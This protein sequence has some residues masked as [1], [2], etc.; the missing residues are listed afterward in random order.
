MVNKLSVISK[1]VEQYLIFVDTCSLMHQN[2]S[3]F[4]N[5]RFNEKIKDYN[6][7]HPDNKTGYYIIQHVIDELKKFTDE[8]KWKTKI[9][10]REKGKIN[11]PP[12]NYL[13]KD[14]RVAIYIV[15]IILSL[16]LFFLNYGAHL[17]PIHEGTPRAE[18]LLTKLYNRFILRSFGGYKNNKIAF[19]LV[20]ESSCQGLLTLV[21]SD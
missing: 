20:K 10:K 19:V 8:E 14:F 6:S 16:L 5:A 18:D 2:A 13:R 12:L 1:Y 3:E 9:K 17:I 11:P 15:I 4:F 21:L 7:K